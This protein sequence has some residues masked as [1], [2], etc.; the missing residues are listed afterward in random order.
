[1]AVAQTHVVSPKVLNEIRVQF[2]SRRQDV[3]SLDPACGGTCERNDQGGPQVEVLG[4]A[5]AGRQRYTPQPRTNRRL[6]MVDTLSR[7]TEAHQFKAGVDYSYVDFTEQSIPLVFGGRYIFAALPAI[8][9][10]LPSAVSS[11][12]A[13]ALGL[14]VAYVQGYGESSKPFG[15]HD[16]SLFAQDDWR[17]RPNLTLNLGVRYQK[18]FYP[19]FAGN[20]PGLGATSFPADNND[21]APRLAFSW[22]PRGNRATLLRGAYGMYYG[23]QLSAIPGV[24]GVVTGQP[25][26]VRLLVQT[27][28]A[29]IATWQAPGRQL[30]EPVGRYPSFV[31]AVDP[32]MRTPFTH[33]ALFGVDRALPGRIALS[34]NVVI[35][36]GFN[37]V[38]AIDYNPLLADLGPGRRPLDTIDPTTG[39]A[40]PGSSTTVYQWTDFGRT[41]YQAIALSATRRAT[42]GHQ[43]AVSYTLSKAEDLARDHNESSPQNQGRGR[44]PADPNGLPI[45]FDPMSE[46]GPSAQDQR[47]RLVAAGVYEAFAGVRLSSIVTVGSGRPYNIVAGADLNGDGDA[48]DVSPDRARVNPADPA[49][50]L[51]RNAGSMP[52][53]ATIDLRV[54]R[55][56]ALHAHARLEVMLEAFNLFNRTNF[57]EI[58]NVFG[59]G[60][61][62]QDPQ[63]GFGQFTQAA[64]PRQIQLAARMR[65]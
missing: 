65:F 19:T 25:D 18:Q 41:W 31:I 47:H 23:N 9:G 62:P 7:F 45:G 55:V 49:S 10:V 57:T 27:F 52:Y 29:S 13:L 17:L 5:T 33:Q 58:N 28:P 11:I 24:S 21:V 54:S 56:F 30:P 14:P 37:F 38:E 35:A 59:V 26:G 36:R 48:G 3:L 1:M 4:V 22:D 16:V 44:N 50:S 2:S 20:V 51:G 43:I 15:Y 32:D 61:Y 6:Q 40:I 53:Q 64:A 34:A 12:Q 39:V 63:Q 60:S 42:R 8:P 46:K